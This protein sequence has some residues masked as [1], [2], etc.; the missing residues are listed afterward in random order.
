MK[1]KLRES[2]LMLQDVQKENGEINHKLTLISS[3]KEYEVGDLKYQLE[4]LTKKL[5]KKQLEF[6]AEKQVGFEY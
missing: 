1:A 5:E 3:T 2:S 6:D 4:N